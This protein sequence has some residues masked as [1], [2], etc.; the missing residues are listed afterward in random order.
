MNVQYLLHLCRSPPRVPSDRKRKMEGEYKEQPLLNILIQ[1]SKRPSVLTTGRQSLNSSAFNKSRNGNVSVIDVLAVSEDN[2][3]V[4]LVD[5]DK[6][7][8]QKKTK[9]YSLLTKQFITKQKKRSPLRTSFNQS[10]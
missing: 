2:K 7:E 10:M 8:K 5:S 6:K 9:T 4:K 1:R 3:V